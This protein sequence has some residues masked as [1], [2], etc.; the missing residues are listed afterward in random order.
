LALFKK[1]EKVNPT[2]IKAPGEQTKYVKDMISM[3]KSNSRQK[4]GIPV[5][6]GTGKVVARV[7]KKPKY[8]FLNPRRKG[9]LQIPKSSRISRKWALK[10]GYKFYVCLDGLPCRTNTDAS[11]PFWAKDRTDEDLHPS[12]FWFENEEKF[13]MLQ[14]ATATMHVRSKEFQAK[15]AELA[16]GVVVISPES[17]VNTSE[18]RAIERLR[19]MTGKDVAISLDIIDCPGKSDGTE[20]NF[21]L[22]VKSWDDESFDS[23][24][25][26][27]ENDAQR[28]KWILHI[29]KFLTRRLLHQTNP[30][31]KYSPKIASNRI[32]N[33]KTKEG[34]SS[35]GTSERSSTRIHRD[36]ASMKPSKHSPKTKGKST[37]PYNLKKTK[38]KKIV[39]QL[40]GDDEDG[41]VASTNDFRQEVGKLAMAFDRKASKIKKERDRT[42]VRRTS[43]MR[44]RTSSGKARSPIGRS[45]KISRSKRPR[46]NTW[47]LSKAK[48][49]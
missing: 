45:Q 1:L 40:N 12:I 25:F 5:K 9:Y 38:R 14:K 3:L 44:R 13:N 17:T 23:H 34:D 18:R 16:M 43:S 41:P 4:V 6:A 2:R 24:K 36:S 28:D 11:E 35:K 15:F 31:T 46:A 37:I 49:L 7:R 8:H 30:T 39:I 19:A 47:S 22:V 21:F 33:I 10:F 29:Q 48:S 20:S 32:N 42:R 26:C 27:A